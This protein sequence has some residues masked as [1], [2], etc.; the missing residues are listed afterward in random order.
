MNNSSDTHDTDETHTRVPCDHKL[1]YREIDGKTWSVC[2]RC[3]FG[4]LWE[5]ELLVSSTDEAE[6]ERLTAMDWAESA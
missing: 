2:M 1:T 5:G 3:G 6:S 4:E